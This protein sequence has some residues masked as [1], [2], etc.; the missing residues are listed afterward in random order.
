MR[1]GIGELLIIL[2]AL[3]I[4]APKQLPKLTT[5][6]SDSWK[7]VKESFKENEVAED[8]KSG[9]SEAKVESDAE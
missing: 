2:I 3:L 8:D 7:K 9:V 5:A 6:V 1:L 4:I